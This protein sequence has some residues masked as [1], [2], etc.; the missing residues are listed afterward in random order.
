MT[1]EIPGEIRQFLKQNRVATLCY[2]SK[3]GFPAC[4]NCFYVFEERSGYLVFKSSEGARHEPASLNSSA[5]S[6]T[7]LPEH[8]DAFH[9]RGLSFSGQSLLSLRVKELRLADVY[10]KQYGF[11][12]LLPGY[13]WAIELQRLRLTEHASG[14][15]R[16]TKW[17]KHSDRQARVS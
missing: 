6:G 3:K 2:V 9:S 13:V 7:I 12:R 8:F 11:T 10:H 16:R 4:I 1:H 5:F 15:I 14:T 17:E